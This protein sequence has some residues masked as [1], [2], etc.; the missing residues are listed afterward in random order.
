MA[1]ISTYAI[2]AT[3][4]LADKVIG[5]DVNDSNITKN[6]T[7]G[8]IIDLVPAPIFPS[9]GAQMT[10]GFVPY[11]NG[12][13]FV[14]TAMEIIP[15]LTPLTLFS[16]EP[17]EIGYSDPNNVIN[18]LQVKGTS[19]FDSS[20]TIDAKL[21]ANG[22]TSAPTWAVGNGDIEG[23]SIK[24]DTISKG[25]IYIIDENVTALTD[26]LSTVGGV[27]GTPVNRSLLES[28]IFSIGETNNQTFRIGAGD[29]IGGAINNIISTSGNSTGIGTGAFQ[30]YNGTSTS[31]L[32][33]MGRNNTT[34][35]NTNY[36]IIGGR[37]NYVGGNVNEGFI[38]GEGNSVGAS[39]ITQVPFVAREM[40]FDGMFVLGNAN[41]LRSEEMSGTTT[42]SSANGTYCIGSRNQMREMDIDN[43]CLGFGNSLTKRVD[44]DTT[45]GTVRNSFMIGGD[46]DGQNE[47][48]AFGY[49]NEPNEYPQKGSFR[50]DVKIAIATTQ[51]TG[52]AR[53]NAFMIT[54][55]NGTGSQTR[56]QFYLPPLLTKNFVDDAAANAGGILAGG[57]Y[58]TDGVVKICRLSP[59]TLRTL[60]P[61][62]VEQ[63]QQRLRGQIYSSGEGN[64]GS[65]GFYYGQD[66]NYLNNTRTQVTTTPPIGT[67]IMNVSATVGSTPNTL[68]YATFY[69]TSDGVEY[70]GQTIQAGTL[71]NTTPILSTFS[72]ANNVA[73]DVTLRFLAQSDGNNTITE[74][75]FYYGKVNVYN[76]PS[77]EKIAIPNAPF[78]VGAI[79]ELGLTGLDPGETYYC[80][81]YAINSEGEYY[82]PTSDSWLQN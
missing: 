82:D 42:S 57:L 62:Q 36:S 59:P 48:M 65:T 71:A 45:F 64:M 55:D 27:N 7:L 20:P 73:G 53:N 22:G 40:N 37:S 2:D 34:L 5:T 46:L 60:E 74:C 77:N 63:T 39:S 24:Y 54:E 78:A 58:H 31:H 70:V 38:F 32:L 11:W 69:T 35:L 16:S 79:T 76:D 43:F 15:G 12:S 29:G 49:R 51:I 30:G 4:T 23:V 9:P 21:I 44:D 8:D 19:L 6:Y 81:G 50:G 3:P 68:Y 1:K 66:S 18:A 26:V 17:I 47:S 56:A 33:M 75:G 25:N 52:N 41:V 10:N 61:D 67:L 72:V 14:D 13:S 28:N 80:W